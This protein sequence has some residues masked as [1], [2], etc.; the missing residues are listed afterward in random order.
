M[1][2]RSAAV[3]ATILGLAADVAAEP[4]PWAPLRF[5]GSVTVGFPLDGDL[6][7]TNVEIH[8]LQ[9]AGSVRVDGA[10]HGRGPIVGIGG[11]GGLGT[12]FTGKSDACADE[13]TDEGNTRWTCGQL[14]LGPTAIVG[15]AW[16]TALES[17]FVRQDGML[18][19]RGSPH[20][21]LVKNPERGTAE[22]GMTSA[23]GIAFRPFAIE[24]AWTKFPG[25]SYVGVSIGLSASASGWLVNDRVIPAADA[26][27]EAEAAAEAAAPLTHWRID[28]LGG[29]VA[30]VAG[31]DREQTTVVGD[32]AL[33]RIHGF[34]DDPSHAWHRWRGL[35]GEMRY[36]G[37]GR[38]D[39]DTAIQFGPV[40]MAGTARFDGDHPRVAFYGRVAPMIGWRKRG[41]D[42][43]FD[44]GAFAAVGVTGGISEGLGDPEPSPDA[45]PVSL[46]LELTAGWMRDGLYL[47]GS[48]GF[49]LW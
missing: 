42:D 16:G 38:G 24:A 18:Y 10:G 47:G 21:A 37:S 1:Q 11:T 49:V 39:G 17:G 32:I 31:A 9:Q 6:A 3:V 5:G 44:Y 4:A 48:V 36:L 13:V 14:T 30:P 23:V 46:G 43:S 20:F 8:I 15:W 19:L 7:L 2:Y 27:A 26:A 25:D 41:T 22:V 29:P 40:L 28:F 34:P 33:S 12:F 45:S 35:G